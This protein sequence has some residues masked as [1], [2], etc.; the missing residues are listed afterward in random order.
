MLTFIESA[1]VTPDL[2]LRITQVLD[3]SL[4]YI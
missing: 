2:N 3:P 1:D 4:S